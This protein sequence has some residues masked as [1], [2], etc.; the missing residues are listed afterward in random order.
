[1]TTIFQI[2]LLVVFMLIL[3]LSTG[4]LRKMGCIRFRRRRLIDIPIKSRLMI[5]SNAWFYR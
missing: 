3:L 1:M 4:L 5:N 2:L